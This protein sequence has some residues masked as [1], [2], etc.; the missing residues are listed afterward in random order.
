MVVCQ[1]TNGLPWGEAP[2]AASIH[3]GKEGVRQNLA[4]VRGTGEFTFERGI[5]AG[6]AT[7]D[8][9]LESGQTYRIYGWTIQPD[10]NRTRFTYDATEHGLLVNDADVRT[11]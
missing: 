4:V 3:S 10:E 5:I 2:F 11:F 6:P 9:S 7:G 1:R 8:T